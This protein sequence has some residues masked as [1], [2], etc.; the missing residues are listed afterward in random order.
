MAHAER[1]DEAFQRDGPALLDRSEQIAHRSLAV[2]LDVLQP[3]PGVAR[4][5]REDVSRLFHPSLLVEI[6][7]LLLAEP[8]DIEGAAR[9][10][11][12]Q[13][14]DLLVGTGEFAGAAGPRPLLAG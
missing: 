11:Q 2:T 13:V 5:Q 3:D 14:F 9:G 12:F 4:S 7:D 10:E 6:R 8:L 1:I